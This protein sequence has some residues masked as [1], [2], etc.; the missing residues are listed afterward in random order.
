MNIFS[1]LIPINIQEGIGQGGPIEGYDISVYHVVTDFKL[2]ST[3]DGEDT[4]KHIWPVCLP[5]NDAEF[6]QDDGTKL[7]DGFIAGWLDTPS[8]S[9]VDPLK[10]G[11]ESATFEGPR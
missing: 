3:V 11:A 6:V 4:S 8:V 5:K 1:G 7:T 10:L 2:G 9:Q